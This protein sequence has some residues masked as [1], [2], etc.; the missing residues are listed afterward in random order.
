MT[1]STESTA[2]G[3]VLAGLEERQTRRFVAEE[4]LVMRRGRLDIL[5]LVSVLG[6]AVLLVGLGI[7]Y[8]LAP[9]VGLGMV[10]VALVVGDLGMV[11]TALY[12]EFFRKFFR[13]SKPPQ[14]SSPHWRGGLVHVWCSYSPRTHPVGGVGAP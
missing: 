14:S 6:L 3:E 7:W 12:R 10:W 11:G 1:N 8:V 9:N 13:Q 4:R 5:K 2:L